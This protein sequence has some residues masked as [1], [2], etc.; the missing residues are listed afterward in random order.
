VVCLQELKVVDA[1]FPGEEMRALGYFS[2]SHGQRTYNGVAILARSELS[3]VALGLDDGVDDWQARLIAATVNGVRVI[4]VYVPNGGEV[5]A[6]KWQYKLAWLKR[7]RGFLDRHCTPGDR[8]LV[9]GDFNVAPDDADVARPDVWRHSVLCHDDG[10]R[11]LAEV[12]GFGL[13]DVLRKHHPQGGVYS[14]WD[15]RML[16]FAKNDGLRIDLIYS[17]SSLATASRAAF[18]DREARKGKQPSDHAPV[19]AEFEL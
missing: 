10:R 4:C 6:D 11:A 16:G 19:V 17:T 2:A 9:C 8:L 3:D 7:L 12:V 18:V 15:Y 14:W 5:G 1:E 13:V